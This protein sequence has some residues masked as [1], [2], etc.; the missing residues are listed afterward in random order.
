MINDLLH[1]K[2]GYMAGIIKFVHVLIILLSLFHVAKNDDGK[3][4][5][6]FT[7]LLIRRQYSSNVS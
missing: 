6:L 1:A 3:L 4:L 7:I 5:L 2:R